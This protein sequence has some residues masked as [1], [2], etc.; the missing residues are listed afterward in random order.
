M[1]VIDAIESK[2]CKSKQ[3]MGLKISQS[4][5][6]NGLFFCLADLYMQ[7]FL[8]VGELAIRKTIA[9]AVT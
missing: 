4:Y 5:Y 7:E 2:M 8:H 1:H 9:E 6:S 3:K